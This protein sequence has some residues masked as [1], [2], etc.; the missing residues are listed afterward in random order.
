MKVKMKPWMA[1][2]L[3]LMLVLSPNIQA[4]GAVSAQTPVLSEENSDQ[5]NG[6]VVPVDT[7]EEEE[8]YQV[9]D[10][11]V[12]PLY[13]DV[14]RPEELKQTSEAQPGIDLYSETE[15][16]D[17]VE[18]AGE[19]IREAMKQRQETIVIYYQAPEYQDGIL[20][21]IAEQALAH[22]GDAKEGDYLRWQY[23]GWSAEGELRTS[24]NMTYMTFTYTY[25]YYT[26]YEQEVILDEQVQMVLDEL[27][28]YDS[29]TYNKIKAVYDYICQ[30]T[31]YDYD[32]LNDEN[33]KLKYTAYAALVDGKAV[34]QGYALL[35]YRMALELGIDNRIISGTG[36]QEPH[37]WNIVEINGVYYNADTTWDAGQNEYGYFLKCDQNFQDHVR[38]EEYTTQEFYERYPMGTEDYE[39]MQ[40]EKLETPDIVSVYSKQQTTAKVTW[41]VTDGAQGYELFRS[42]DPDASEESWTLTKTIRDGST[43]E[44]TNTGLTPGK[45]YY[46][47]VRAFA[48]N[49][50][51]SEVYSEF[52][53]VNYMPAAVLFDG[54]YSNSSSR[55][56]IRWEPV[57]GA[58]GYQIWRQ[59]DD[60]AFRIVKII[61]A[62]EE[63]Q[64]L[65]QC[66]ETA[67]S[68]T[69]L[70][71]GKE[72]VYRMR[73]YTFRGGN[74]V[75]GAYS[76]DISVHVMLEKPFLTVSSPKEGRALL[77]WNVINGAHGYQIWRSES[78]DTGYSIVKVVRES[79]VTSYTNTDLESGKT[80]YY[81]VRAYLETGGNTTYGEYSEPVSID[82]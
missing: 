60:G 50:D 55:I 8:T 69:G 48:V 21:E 40:I 10:I 72:Y 76:D 12:N 51:D 41:T 39:F 37:G 19:Q 67:Y 25:T 46:Y 17:T 78:E 64:A 42:E 3:T 63:E 45:T 43:V 28:V 4:F 27:N 59:E 81:K 56:R 47:K 62:R 33:Y 38:D 5:N 79:D 82:M 13:R 23:G 6:D 65:G 2:L 75:Y 35:F 77:S 30:H 22:T 16:A 7:S 32:N 20:R 74:V 26:T 61:G 53:E 49:D 14:L 18:E 80:Y 34:C 52:S 36:N 1:L 11:Y 54:P 29:G 71:A 31:S 24:G 15:Y 44:Y 73:A 66:E 57:K 68:N 58:Q 9:K 70:E